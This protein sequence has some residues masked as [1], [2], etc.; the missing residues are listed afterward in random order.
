MLK[1]EEILQA[2]DLVFEDVEVPEWGGTVRVRC[3]TAAERDAF[4]ATILKQT[5]SGVRVEMS[6]LRAKLCAMTIVDEDGNR[7][8]SDAEAELLG[9][10]SASALQRIFEVAMRLSRFTQSEIDALADNLKNAPHGGSL[11]G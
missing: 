1:R 8:F 6:N 7:M 4:E 10:K 5:Q 2:N 3:L 9:R 11:I